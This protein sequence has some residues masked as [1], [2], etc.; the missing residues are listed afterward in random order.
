MKYYLGVDLGG[1]NIAVGV[2]DENYKIISKASLKTNA[3]RPAGDIAKDIVTAANTSLNDAGVKMEEIENIG[4]GA[5]GV[6]NS[7]TGVMEYTSNLEFNFEPMADIVQSLTEKQVFLENDANAAALGELVCGAGKG[8]DN[9]VAVTLGTGVGGGIIIDGKIFSGSN[10]AGGE[11]GHMV[12]EKGG[13]P[14]SCG[15]L[16]CFESYCTAPA[17]VKRTEYLMS[18]NPNSLLNKIVGK[19]GKANGK[20]AF[21]AAERGDKVGKEIV[22]EYISYLACGIIN[23]INIFQPEVICI[24]GGISK[25]GKKLTNPIQKLADIEEYGRHGKKRVK[26]VT[27]Q[28]GN[29]AGIIGAAMLSAYR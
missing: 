2:V 19:N 22:E 23:I 18:K 4:M 5:P 11:I 10:F 6:I 16:G 29:D 15:R 12:I 9:M 8:Y 17:L 3:P 25:E 26:I 27:A 1:T 20:T 24:G 14:C 21:T 13:R 28:L 7:K